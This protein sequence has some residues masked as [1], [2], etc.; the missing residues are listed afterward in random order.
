M[1]NLVLDFFDDH[2]INFL[3]VNI[4]RFSSNI[5][6][7]VLFLIFLVDVVLEEKVKGRFLDEDVDILNDIYLRMV[8]IQ[9]CLSL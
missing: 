7:M 1:N 8:V 3:L 6:R 2:L 5:R 9:K 4:L